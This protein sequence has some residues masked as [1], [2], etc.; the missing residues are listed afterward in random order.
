[1]TIAELIQTV[2]QKNDAVEYQWLNTATI[3]AQY[4][5]TDATKRKPAKRYT[6]ITFATDNEIGR[7]FLGKQENFI[8]VVV[9]LPATELREILD[10]ASNHSAGITDNV[11]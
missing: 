11:G 7:D 6:E 8:G 4:H 10:S 9:W 2:Q 5:N 3:G 1:M